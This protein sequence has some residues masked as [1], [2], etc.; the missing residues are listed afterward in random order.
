MNSMLLVGLLLYAAV[1]ASCAKHNLRFCG[2]AVRS[3]VRALQLHLQL[4][5]GL[6]RLLRSDEAANQTANEQDSFHSGVF[7]PV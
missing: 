7:F 5:H 6:W 4:H 1:L 3:N 2:K